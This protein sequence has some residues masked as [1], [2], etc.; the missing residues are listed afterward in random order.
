MRQSVLCILLVLYI[1]PNVVDAQGDY[2]YTNK[3]LHV[4]L[5]IE[6]QGQTKNAISCH[7][8]SN[9]DK[10]TKYS[11]YEVTEYG[12]K[13]GRVYI[14]RDIQSKDTVKRVF[15]ERLVNGK[16]TLFLYKG[17]DYKEFYLEK[18]SGVLIP[19]IRG[20]KNNNEPDYRET[21]GKCTGDCAALQEDLNLV[22]YNDKS[23]ISFT[24]AYNKCESGKLPYIKYGV[25]FG[26]VSTSLLV[27]SGVRYEF[28]KG[29]QIGSDGSLNLSFFID[30]PIGRKGFSF[31]P[32][33][34]Y[35]RNNF[36]YYRYNVNQ[37]WL[38]INTSC[39][40]FPLMFRYTL[41]VAS[42]KVAPY[43]NAGCQASFLLK[44]DC[45]VLEDSM[46][47]S[48]I[49]AEDLYKAE[50]LA[51]FYVGYVTGAGLQFN[52]HHR[53]NFFAEFRYSKSYA[54]LEPTLM[55]KGEYFLLTGISF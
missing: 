21:L 49:V 55:D 15:L 45:H 29:S 36:D 31:H 32:E 5:Q 26:Y 16:L 38:V 50:L 12:F 14:A 22:I 48:I 4:G 30:Y 41:P 24:E 27:S 52:I 6:D 13:D 43:I 18:D 35:I 1:L 25:M 3:S 39:I 47:G 53:I 46:V 51:P 42:S 34:Q 10:I 23:L 7:V 20:G 28:L 44:N 19:L 54:A 37:T 2:F 33:I 8:S 9:G 40:N 11:P 17:F